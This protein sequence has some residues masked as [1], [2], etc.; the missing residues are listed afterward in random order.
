M[1]APTIG[2]VHALQ[3]RFLSIL[4]TIEAH[5]RAAFRVIRC[6][7]D[8]DDAVAEVV[9]RAWELFVTT[10]TAPVDL[11]ALPVITEVQK[12]LTRSACVTY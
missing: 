2:T 12:E 7:H 3:H 11:L 4:P 9:V 6:S 5:A 8:R 10:P 1:Q